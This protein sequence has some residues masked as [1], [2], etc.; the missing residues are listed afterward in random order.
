MARNY[1]V[2][3]LRSERDGRFYTGLTVDLEKRIREHQEGLSK[4][5]K[6]KGPWKL[7]WYGVFS[8]IQL[9]E[10]FER[11]LKTGSGI[12]FCRKRLLRV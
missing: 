7:K 9:A 3:V 1:L 10:K 11:Y 2:Y 6:N 8:D 12:A 4:Y 5:T